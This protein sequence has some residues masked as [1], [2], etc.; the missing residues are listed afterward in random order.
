MTFIGLRGKICKFLV[1]LS[2]IG[3]LTPSVAEMAKPTSKS[4]VGEVDTEI[5]SVESAF[6]IIVAKKEDFIEV[7]WLI[8]PGCYVYR[9]KLFFSPNL[10][11]IYI[12]KGDSY[13]DIFF[14]EV[15][16]YFDELTVIIPLTSKKSP[17]KNLKVSFQGCS[18]LGF[19]YP[20]QTREINF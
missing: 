3:V 15:E 20:S 13:P 12:P 5:L 1:L 2:I 17:V 16:V 7:R 11:G 4:L 8:A 9:D 14:G 10:D 19:C 18:E 6:Q